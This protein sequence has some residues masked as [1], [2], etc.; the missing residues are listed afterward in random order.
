MWRGIRNLPRSRKIL[1]GGTVATGGALY[2]APFLR[3][4]FDFAIHAVQR[5]ST[6]ALALSRCVIAYRSTLKQEY[7]SEDDYNKALS[8]C[9]LK[10]ALITR[11]ALERNA[12]IFIKLGQHISALT[13][14]FPEEWTKTMVPLQDQCPV[15]SLESI[16]EMFR[17]DMQG[18]D[19]HDVFSEFSP[20][21]MGTAS[22]AQVHKATLRDSGQE[23]AVKV[24]HPSLK[25]Y[26]PLD[27]LLTERVF[28]LITYFF[29]QYPL[30]WLS[31]EMRRS[32]F[33]ELDFTT[34][35]KNAARTAE[36]FSSFE[37]ETR[38]KV[39]KVFWAKPRVLCMEFV[40]GIRPDHVD[41]LRAA[42]VDLKALSSCFAHLFNNMIFTPMVGLHC[43]PHA[44]N[45]AIR[46]LNKDESKHGKVGTDFEVVLYDH[47]LYRYVDTP[48][49]V[50]YAHFWVALMENNPQDM[51]KYAKQFAHIS[52]EDFKVFAA[53]ITGRDF[54]SS[55]DGSVL[56]KPRSQEEISNMQ[57]AMQQ[58]EGLASQVMNMLRNMPPV[59]LLILKTNDLVRY[60]DEV[61]GSPLGMKQQFAVMAS[62]CAR[63]ILGQ[64]KRGGLWQKISAYF[65]YFVTM[66]KLDLLKLLG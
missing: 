30:N 7:P 48:T 32:I 53:A 65:H 37:K 62:Y 64:E 27:V 56:T 61:L 3:D 14:I 57:R 20:E 59:V 51:H 17:H 40:S 8:D 66:V 39:P 38:L 55:T 21:P 13:Y 6:V 18:K 58:D 33:V 46:P 12:G 41:E 9:H 47:G 44:G 16:E 36:Y 2:F 1:L 11:N 49:R 19:L 60:L 5:S 29:P 25:R 26:V 34:E 42:G 50:A 43:D 52:D 4:D 54:S 45:I 28:N 31:D 15:S 10:C 24:Q 63:T 23:V 22:L 35:A